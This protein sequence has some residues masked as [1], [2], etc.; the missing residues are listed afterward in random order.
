MAPFFAPPCSYNITTN[1]AVPGLSFGGQVERLRREYR[2]AKGFKFG[3][4][5]S[6]SQCG[7]GLE[8]V[9]KFFGFFDSE[10]YILRTF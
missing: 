8:R 3:E 10:W 1:D 4:W 6:P 5:V 7:M 9:Q 2:G